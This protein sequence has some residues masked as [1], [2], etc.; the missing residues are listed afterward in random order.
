MQ[1]VFLAL[2]TIIFLNPQGEPYVAQHWSPTVDSR[3]EVCEKRADDMA[4]IVSAKLLAKET[5]PH[6]NIVISYGCLEI[7]DTRSL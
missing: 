4:N 1:T 7:E 5:I 6:E 3:Q 2:V